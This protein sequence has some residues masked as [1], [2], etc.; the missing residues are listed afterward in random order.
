MCRRLHCC[1]PGGEI[2]TEFESIAGGGSGEFANNVAL[3]VLIRAETDGMIGGFR[4]PK[5]EA[6]VMLASEDDAPAARVFEDG[7]NRVCVEG[8]GVEDGGIFVAIA[9]FLIGE[10]V[11]GEMQKV[12]EAEFAPAELALR[13]QDTVRRGRF[14]GEGERSGGAGETEQKPA[15]RWLID[16]R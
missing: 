2:N 3:A 10:G 13:G 11:D 8:G 15:A 14:G 16:H 5:T 9:P 7:T 12:V 1:D 4:G 6:I